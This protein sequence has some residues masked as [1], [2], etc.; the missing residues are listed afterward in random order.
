MSAYAVCGVDGRGIMRAKR[1]GGRGG[2]EGRETYI[3]FFCSAMTNNPR[4]SMPLGGGLVRG[5]PISLPVYVG[6]GNACASGT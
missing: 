1:E 6:A 3:R 2:G 4:R 5:V